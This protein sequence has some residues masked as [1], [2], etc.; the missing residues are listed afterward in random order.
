VAALDFFSQCAGVDSIWAERAVTAYEQNSSWH[1]Q[2]FV[3]I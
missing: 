3:V 1:L 2:I